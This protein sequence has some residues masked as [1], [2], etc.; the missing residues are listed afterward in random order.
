MVS[1]RKQEIVGNHTKAPVSYCLNVPAG[2]G[3]GPFPIESASEDETQTR[4]QQ[5]HRFW[6]KHLHQINHSVRSV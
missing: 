5:L 3:T 1:D 4:Q 2:K 6:I